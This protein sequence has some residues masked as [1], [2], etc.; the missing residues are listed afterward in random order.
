[1]Q[2][3]RVRPSARAPARA[4]SAKGG[5][6]YAPRAGASRSAPRT[7]C[8]RR[9]GPCEPTGGRVR[10]GAAQRACPR[11]WLRCR[12]PWRWGA[13]ASHAGEDSRPGERGVGAGS[14]DPSSPGRAPT[15]PGNSQGAAS[16]SRQQPLSGRTLATRER[17]EVDAER[18]RHGAHAGACCG[19][20]C[21]G[22][23]AAR[24][25]H[26]PA[27]R[28]G[29]SLGDGQKGPRSRPRQPTGM[30]VGP[31]R[32]QRGAGDPGPPPGARS[33]R[34]GAGSELPPPREPSPLNLRG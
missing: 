1:M 30:G 22:S 14:L 15:L 7:E 28:S 8:G 32:Q 16:C 10:D 25:G 34:A 13:R 23:G 12:Q 18:K 2:R 11:L 5:S 27:W 26:S 20:R 24:P 21:L 4:D 33:R 3:Q 17:Q 6:G 9:G 29:A 31:A 19:Y